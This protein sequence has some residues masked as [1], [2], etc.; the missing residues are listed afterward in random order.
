MQGGEHH[1]KSGVGKLKSV[2]SQD[3]RSVHTSGKHLGSMS[4]VKASCP[5][6]LQTLDT[7]LVPQQISQMSIRFLVPAG[8]Y[9]SSRAHLHAC[10]AR[11]SNLKNSPRPLQVHNIRSYRPQ[12]CPLPVVA[13]RRG[14]RASVP[15]RRQQLP[16]VV[17]IKWAALLVLCPKP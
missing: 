2:Y 5:A 14:Q 7:L 10:E 11:N 13:R 15:V 12:T 3:M 1:M 8:W 9:C 4:S 17:L 16:W 6:S